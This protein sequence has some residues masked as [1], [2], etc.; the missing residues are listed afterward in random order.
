[1]K[2]RFLIWVFTSFYFSYCFPQDRVGIKLFSKSYLRED[3]HFH[4][5][6]P[7][8]VPSLNSG[9]TYGDISVKPDDDIDD[10]GLPPGD[11]SEGDGGGDNSDQ[12]DNIFERFFKKTL[13][14]EFI[15]LELLGYQNKDFFIDGGMGVYMKAVKEARW[16]GSRQRKNSTHSRLCKSYPF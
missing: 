6:I 10:E 14:L 15:F 11:N 8:Y 1:M 4:F 5:N 13:N 12:G 9:F 16:G 3:Q 2:I 7:I